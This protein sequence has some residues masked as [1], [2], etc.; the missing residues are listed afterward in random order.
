MST[1]ESSPSDLETPLFD[2]AAHLSD[3]LVELINNHIDPSKKKFFGH[4][5]KVSTFSHK[6]WQRFRLWF[7]LIVCAPLFVIPVMLNGLPGFLMYATQWTS[8]ITFTY[9]LLC[10]QA[11]RKEQHLEDQLE[12]FVPDF[13]V[14][15]EL[16][17]N[18]IAKAVEDTVFWDYLACKAQNLVYPCQWTVVFSFWLF[19]APVYFKIPD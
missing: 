1:I 3:E 15:S 8:F 17:E 12:E 7:A 19:I 11:A 16:A 4:F 2:K 10:W 18:A 14:N 13:G 5:H 6:T 9:F